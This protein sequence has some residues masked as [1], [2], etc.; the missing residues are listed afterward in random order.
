MKKIIHM[1]EF[2]SCKNP[3]SKKKL[4]G[5]FS[6]IGSSYKDTSLISLSNLYLFIERD[7]FLAIK[8][9]ELPKLDAKVLTY[10][11]GSKSFLKVRIKNVSGKILNQKFIKGKFQAGKPFKLDQD[12]FKSNYFEAYTDLGRYIKFKIAQILWRYNWESFQRIDGEIQSVA[13]RFV[14]SI[15][16]PLTYTSYLLRSVLSLPNEIAPRIKYLIYYGDKS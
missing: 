9:G 6:V 1:H 11:R 3:I 7:I 13:K 16:Y 14:S 4:D 8:K 15:E 10:K 2:T 5:K 12:F